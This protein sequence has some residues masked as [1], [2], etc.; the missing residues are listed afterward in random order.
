MLRRV[1]RVQ[2]AVTN[3]DEAEKVVANIFGGE[4]LRRDEVGP[5]RA[6][7]ATTQAGASLIELVQP[8][9]PGPVRE[10]IDRSGQGLFAAGFSVDDLDA[11]AHHLESQ[12]AKFERASGQLFLDTSATF[13][14][15]AVISARH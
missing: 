1:D 13:G 10:F 4:P 2:I 3:L 7:R 12:R 15:R 6:R 9:G 8:D 11:A 14:M 5:L